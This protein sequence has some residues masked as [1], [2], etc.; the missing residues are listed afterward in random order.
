[1]KLKLLT[2]SLFIALNLSAGGY[3][4]PESSLNAVSLSAAYIANT[5]GADSSYYNPA[6]MSFNKNKNYVELG[7]TTIVLPK[8]NFTH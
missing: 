5:S 6:N 7:L 3:K 2:T 1:M 4:I 8:I